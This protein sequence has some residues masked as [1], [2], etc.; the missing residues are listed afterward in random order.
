L[1]PLGVPA[2]RK[3]FL[4]DPYQL[5]EARA[6]GAGGALLIVRMLNATRL[7]DMLDAAATHGLF[8]LLEAFDAEDLATAQAALA[9]RAG[10]TLVG[11]LAA[12]ILLGINCRDLQT[13][14]VV[15]ERF[16][17]LAAQLPASW[18]AVA[19]S[20]VASPLDAARVKQ[21]GFRLALMG[22]ALMAQ[23][24]PAPL[25]QEILVATR[26]VQS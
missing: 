5:L 16:D 6:A 7:A 22:T 26:T 8:V 13:L 3:D 12:P 9:A 19:E 11:A 1:R 14:E 21:L 10:R 20:G 17:S 15:Q 23:D 2:M 25:L 24:D 4:V 18:P